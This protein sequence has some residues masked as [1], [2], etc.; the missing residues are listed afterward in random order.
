MQ[1]RPNS[2]DAPKPN[3]IE[4]ASTRGAENRAALVEAAKSRLGGVGSKLLK[5]VD[6][7]LGVPGAAKEKVVEVMSR[8]KEKMI[9][10]GEKMSARASSAAEKVSQRFIETKDKAG[11]RIAS[12]SKR[13]LAAGLSPVAW[14][15]K[16]V[17]QIRAFPAIFDYT[18]AAGAERQA[19]AQE[20]KAQQIENK[21]LAEAESIEEQIQ[22]LKAQ[23]E[24]VLQ[25][26]QEEAE[27]MRGV[28]DVARV[29]Q[30]QFESQARAM[31]DRA[32]QMRTVRDYISGLRAA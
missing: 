9:Q 7:A 23:Q 1:E 3:F 8:A 30:R 4:N 18:K 10:I 17:S 31:R 20:T 24:A 19:D 2:T 14:G 22:R 29:Q 28:R 11:S 15:E 16:K 26:G 32:A 12:L 5:G 27:R 25:R 13:A 6:F 21:A